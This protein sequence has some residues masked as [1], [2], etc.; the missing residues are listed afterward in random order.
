[1]VPLAKP[2]EDNLGCLLNGHRPVDFG[3]FFMGNGRYGSTCRGCNEKI[4][5]DVR[6]EYESK[7]KEGWKLT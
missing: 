7:G 1:M 3:V 6:E 4:V 2:M 5:L